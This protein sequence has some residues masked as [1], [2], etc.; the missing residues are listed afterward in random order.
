MNNFQK[1]FFILL[2][3]ICLFGFVRA[4]ILKKVWVGYEGSNPSWCEKGHVHKVSDPIKYWLFTILDFILAMYSFYLS[5]CGGNLE[6]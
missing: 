2:G 1:I 5:F 4:L 3:M 6:L